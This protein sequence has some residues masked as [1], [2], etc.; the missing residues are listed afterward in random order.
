MEVHEVYE[1]GGADVGREFDQRQSVS[2]M[3]FSR[4]YLHVLR[5][6]WQGREMIER[7]SMN[8]SKGVRIESIAYRV[9]AYA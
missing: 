9:G 2:F 3:F 4:I 1:R 6:E 5:S 8:V 7:M